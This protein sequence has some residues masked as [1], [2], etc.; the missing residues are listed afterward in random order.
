MLGENV[1]QFR[2]LGK[3]ADLSKFPD[4][5]LDDAIHVMVVPVLS[6]PPASAFN[7]LGVAACQDKLD[8][9]R[10]KNRLT[11]GRWLV[12]ERVVQEAPLPAPDLGLGQRQKPN[13][14]HPS[15]K[16]IRNLREHHQVGR[17]GQQES[18]RPRVPVDQGLDH[19]QERRRPLN[20]VD[21][22]PV[23]ASKEANRVA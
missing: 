19:K 6:S 18:S 3:L 7:H 12:R 23:N 4:V 14:L 11:D 5:A 15:G 17:S 20:L 21:H 10:A 22:C 13:D 16:R 8:Q 2:H 9:I 1:E